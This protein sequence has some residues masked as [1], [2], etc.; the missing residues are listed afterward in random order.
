MKWNANLPG[1]SW[2]KGGN[3]K[4]IHTIIDRPACKSWHTNNATKFYLNMPLAPA[5]ACG[6]PYL[7]DATALISPMQRWW[8][9][10]CLISM[11]AV[12]T[13]P[14]FVHAF[15]FNGAILFCEGCKDV[16]FRRAPLSCS[17]RFH[18][19]SFST[20]LCNTFC[21]LHTIMCDSFLLP[22]WAPVTSSPTWSHCCCT[23]DCV[24]VKSRNL[25]SVC[26]V[27]FSLTQTGA[28]HFGSFRNS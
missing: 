1:G 12:F 7:P 21:M 17:F 25:V 27:R 5:F 2:R 23:D 19:L 6:R 10:Q 28:T 15:L 11:C 18:L 16:L 24:I 26:T 4:I 3:L 9:Q 22:F 8:M 13:F 14:P 20:V